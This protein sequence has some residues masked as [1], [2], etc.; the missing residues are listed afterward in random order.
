MDIFKEYGTSKKEI[1]NTL[2]ELLKDER[3]ENGFTTKAEHIAYT[4]G[5]I[6]SIED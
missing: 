5:I 1:L 4:I 6:D 3:E 2:F